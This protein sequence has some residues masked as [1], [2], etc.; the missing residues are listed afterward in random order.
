MSVNPVTLNLSVIRG[1]TFD[2]VVL[3]LRDNNVVVSG[4]LSPSVVGTFV[5][6]GSYAGYPLFVLAGSPSYFLYYNTAAAS[7]VIAALLTNAALTNYWSPAAPLTEPTG[8]YVAHGANT[9]TATV[10]N[11]PVDLTGNTVEAVVRRHSLADVTLDLNPAITNVGGEVTI[12]S[13]SSDNTRDFDFVGTFSWDL[14][15]VDGTGKRLGPY[16]KGLF[17]VSDNITQKE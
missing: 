11:H 4:T 13:I 12:P 10:T 6:S 17:T 2:A 16:Y 15:R 7:Y 9:G 3:H 1:I 5:L 8:T 14:V